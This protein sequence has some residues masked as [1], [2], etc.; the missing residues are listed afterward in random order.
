MLK[1]GQ[2][3][4]EEVVLGEPARK[5]A[6][7]P[8]VKAFGHHMVVDHLAAGKE[9]LAI[10]AK[11]GIPLLKKVVE[12]IVRTERAIPAARH[13][14]RFDREYIKQQVASHEVALSCSGSP[15]RTQATPQS[16]SMPGSSGP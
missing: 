2:S 12:Q 1:A 5:Q 7:N 11:K 15:P 14:K 4:A 8:D 13:G 9:L 6:T 10:A 16:G 3:N